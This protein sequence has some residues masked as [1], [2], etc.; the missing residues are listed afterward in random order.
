[1]AIQI[2]ASTVGGSAGGGGYV[3]AEYLTTAQTFVFSLDEVQG[4][5]PRFYIKN[6]NG[7]E[8]TNAITG[9][10]NTIQLP[11]N[12]ILVNVTAQQDA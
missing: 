1:M 7:L 6:A 2:T 11:Q 4:A 10:H 3:A 8:Y 12:V 5:N 9:E